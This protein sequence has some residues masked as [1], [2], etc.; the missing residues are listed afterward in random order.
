M[1][2]AEPDERQ[3]GRDARVSRCTRTQVLAFRFHRITFHY[4]G[5]LGFRVCDRSFQQCL[6]QSRIAIRPRGEKTG[7]G[8]GD[9]LV[10][11]LARR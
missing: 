2:D 8:P 5:A 6:H 7:D 1:L 3:R 4:F 11:A 10:E 9:Q